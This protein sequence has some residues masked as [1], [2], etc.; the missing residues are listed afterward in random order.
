MTVSAKNL[1]RAKDF[2]RAWNIEL[3]ITG[4]TRC[5]ELDEQFEEYL[6]AEF[7]RIEDDVHRSHCAAAEGSIP[8]STSASPDRSGKA[9]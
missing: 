4:A 5:K 1:R 7:Q 3:G 2:H 9:E 8:I 6:A